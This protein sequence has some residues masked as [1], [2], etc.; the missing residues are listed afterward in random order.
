MVANDDIT[1][2][3]FLDVESMTVEGATDASTTT[4]AD[5]IAK[6]IMWNHGFGAADMVLRTSA[7]LSNRANDSS[8][9]A[10][11]M[12]DA[13]KVLDTKRVGTFTKKGISYIKHGNIIAFYQPH[14]KRFIRMYDG[15]V[16]GGGGP[17]DVHSLPREWGSER[18][19]VIQK[20][21]KYAFYS[22]CHNAYIREFRKTLD[23]SG[24][25]VLLDPP[26]FCELFKVSNDANAKYGTIL[27]QLETPSG[28]KA[29][30]TKIAD[31]RIESVP[32]PYVG[33]LSLFQVVLIS[34]AFSV[35]N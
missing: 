17:K 24:G 13:V 5:T 22:I 18:F 14:C 33:S 7:K 35:A 15:N 30:Y 1:L 19:L 6:A 3:S 28:M 34:D 23:G 29:S 20:G 2:D 32:N 12:A 27:I 25:E 31:G 16:D 9:H 4:I 21:D 8:P 11:G 10:L 26:R